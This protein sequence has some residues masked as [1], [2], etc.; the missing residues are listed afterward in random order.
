MSI[1]IDKNGRRHVGIM[2]AGKRVHRI[3]PE[4]ATASD[5]KQLDAELRAALARDKTPNIPGDPLL[6]EVMQLYLDHA[7]TLRSPETAKMHALRVGPWVS[8]RRASEAQKVAAVMVKDLLTKYKPATVNRSI[9]ALKK[10]LTLAWMEGKTPEDW[11]A[12]IKRLPENN[13]REVHLSVKEVNKIAEHCSEQVRAAVWVSLLTGCRRGEVLKIAKADIGKKTIT[14]HAGNTKTLRT[15]IVPIIPALRPWLKFLPLDINYE[16]VKSG[17]RRA[18][19]S[20]NMPHVH[21]HDLR[22]SCATI[23]IDSGADLYTVAKIL[24]H[25]TIKTTERYAHHH[26]D[27]QRAALAKAFA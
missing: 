23:L 21:F 26:V 20:A 6:S 27:A 17:F 3:L 10:A 19:E 15:R 7:K 25:T 4:G 1:W 11:G 22:H 18:R 16:G 2:A 12:K 13:Q 5:A 9:G 24:G 14:I 8:N